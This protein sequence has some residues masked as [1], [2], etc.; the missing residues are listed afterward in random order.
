MDRVIFFVSLRKIMASDPLRI[1]RLCQK[2]KKNYQICKADQI[3][4]SD[5]VVVWLL[6]FDQ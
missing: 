5:T 3:R 4:N 6:S 2:E 1:S